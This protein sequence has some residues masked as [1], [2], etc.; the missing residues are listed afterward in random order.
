MSNLTPMDIF[1][2]PPAIS[3]D[4]AAYCRGHKL[5]VQTVNLAK[6]IRA[7]DEATQKVK[8]AEA[9]LSTALEALSTAVGAVREKMERESI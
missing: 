9:V 5:C 3:F 2:A 8:E 1:S 4:I 6:A 7:R